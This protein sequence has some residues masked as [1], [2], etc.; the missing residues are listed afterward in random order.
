[1][2]TN[3]SVPV[4]AATFA[5]SVAG[6]AATGRITRQEASYPTAKVDARRVYVED[7]AR[8]H[9]RNGHAETFHGILLGAQKFTDGIWH[10]NTPETE[11]IQAIK[12]GPG[13]MPAFEGKLSDTEIEALAAYVKTLPPAD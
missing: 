1:M 7:C 2:K 6:C 5:L 10:T 3:L 4:L 11:V 13:G 8:C 9:G 12:T